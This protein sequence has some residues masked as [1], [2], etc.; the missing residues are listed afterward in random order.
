MAAGTAAACQK[1]AFYIRYFAT[2]EKK[3]YFYTRNYFIRPLAELNTNM[4]MVLSAWKAVRSEATITGDEVLG[5]IYR[6]GSAWKAVRLRKCNQSKSCGVVPSRHIALS[7]PFR[8]LRAR[9]LLLRSVVP[10]RH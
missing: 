5:G 10:S 2:S 3:A 4:I 1:R 8:A 7:T 6:N 9:L